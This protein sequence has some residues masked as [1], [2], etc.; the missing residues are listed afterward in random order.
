MTWDLRSQ[1]PSSHTL[2]TL[3]QDEQKTLEI[4]NKPNNNMK[5]F[6]KLDIN[7]P[8]NPTPDYLKSLNRNNALQLPNFS[9]ARA[10]R[11]FRGCPRST[12]Y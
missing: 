5:P 9:P 8:A 11:A 3:H 2:S 12:Y 1:S 4:S 10:P 6:E 7:K